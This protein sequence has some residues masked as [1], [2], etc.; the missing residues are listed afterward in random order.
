MYIYISMNQH[1]ENENTY[2]RKPLVLL[3]N[4]SYS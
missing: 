4:K 2:I 3:V 1:Y